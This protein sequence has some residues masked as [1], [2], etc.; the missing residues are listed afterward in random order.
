M[1]EVPSELRKKFI[2]GLY[3]ERYAIVDYMYEEQYASELAG[4]LVTILFCGTKEEVQKE[5]VKL[6]TDIR[7]PRRKFYVV[8]MGG[9][10]PLFSEMLDE[11][12][13]KSSAKQLQDE[14]EPMSRRYESIL[15]S[16]FI[17]NETLVIPPSIAP[18]SNP[19]E[20]FQKLALQFINIQLECHSAKSKFEE[21]TDKM[22]Y[23]AKRMNQLKDERESITTDWLNN[24]KLSVSEKEYLTTS[25]LWSNL[26]KFIFVR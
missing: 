7:C 13:I 6:S 15:S 12:R 17:P 10:F 25:L 1:E 22:K 24:Y 23:L 14:I 11:E 26:T 20:E 21:G 16:T 2:Q 8:A 5:F 3:G 4:A 18:D 19:V 9:T